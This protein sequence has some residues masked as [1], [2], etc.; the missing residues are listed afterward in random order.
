MFRAESW[1]ATSNS[2]WLRVQRQYQGT[3]GREDKAAPEASANRADF[4]PSSKLFI[5]KIPE[6]Q[7]RGQTGYGAARHP[8]TATSVPAAVVLWRV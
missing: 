2:Q 7:P 6:K 4:V 1:S 8:P 5:S 3:P